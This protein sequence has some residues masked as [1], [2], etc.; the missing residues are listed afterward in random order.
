MMKR[1]MRGAKR[2]VSS[3]YR[4]S[5][6]AMLLSCPWPSW[7]CSRPYHSDEA[8]RGS[9]P[10]PESGPESKQLPKGPFWPDQVFKDAVTGTAVF[11]L[12]VGLTVFLPPSYSGQADTLDT[13]Y[14]PKP[15]GTSSFST[16]A[17]IL[18]GQ[19]R[20]DRYCRGSDRAN[21]AAVLLPFI[22]RNPERNP[23]RRPV[24]MLCAAGLAVLIIWLSVTGHL[25]SGFA[26]PGSTGETKAAQSIT[27]EN[28]AGEVQPDSDGRSC[29]RNAA[30]RK[31]VR[32]NR[33]AARYRTDRPFEGKRTSGKGILHHRKRR[34]GRC[35]VQEALHAVPRTGGGKQTP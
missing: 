32:K 10:W 22:D 24:A 1:F 11:I 8:I 4:A 7:Q 34:G 25:S 33:S 20:A 21:P 15:D 5:S 18:S 27:P 30:V 6:S 28:A 17:E 12:L 29:S 2:W 35:I 3:P 9:G 31:N 23:F 26:L 16:G 19:S 14:V 13:S